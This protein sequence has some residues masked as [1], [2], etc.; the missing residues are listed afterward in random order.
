MYPTFPKFPK[1]QSNI[2]NPLEHVK[3]EI[4]CAYPPNPNRLKE[5]G[6]EIEQT[7]NSRKS[8]LKSPRGCNF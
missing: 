4:A 2:E 8:F 5:S 3:W 6:G 7:K 1:Y